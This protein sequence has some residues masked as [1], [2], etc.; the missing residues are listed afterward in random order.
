MCRGFAKSLRGWKDEN[1]FRHERAH[2][3]AQ[4]TLAGGTLPFKQMEDVRGDFTRTC[5]RGLR[6][7]GAFGEAA[8]PRLLPAGELP[9]ASFHEFDAGGQRI[10]VAGRLGEVFHQL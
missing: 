7:E 8:E 10:R 2:A 6:H 1:V 9:G 3:L 4:L 5:L